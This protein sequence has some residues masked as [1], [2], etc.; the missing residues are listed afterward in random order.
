LW[1]RE[2]ALATHLD[3]QHPSVALEE[4]SGWPNSKEIA[5]GWGWLL[6]QLDWRWHLHLHLVHFPHF[7]NSEYFPF[8]PFF[9]KAFGVWH[10]S[11]FIF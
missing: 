4:V 3:T 6:T 2:K 8:S 10:F 7:A 5:I 9:E 11:P 1:E